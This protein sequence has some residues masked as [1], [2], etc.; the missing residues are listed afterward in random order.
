MNNVK[1]VNKKL[2]PKGTVA[3]VTIYQDS[4]DEK[5]YYKDINGVPVLLNSENNG[6]GGGGTEY[7]PLSGGTMS[8]DIKVENQLSITNEAGT[9]G[10]GIGLNTPISTDKLIGIGDIYDITSP[11]VTG[12]DNLLL[13]G[14]SAL[15]AQDVYFISTDRDNNIEQ[16]F[17]LGTYGPVLRK[18]TSPDNYALM[19][20]DQDEDILLYNRNTEA[21][22]K[23]IIIETQ[24]H[25]TGKV[26]TITVG[27]RSI[28]MSSQ[29]IYIDNLPTHA[30]NIDA[31]AA[32]LIPNAVYKTATGELR[33][34]I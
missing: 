26:S 12:T 4:A 16:S 33:I 13:I 5:L 34:A 11:P 28:R 17:S 32:G 22:E 30:N 9:Y 14:G 24:Y 15:G 19:Q 21:A 3:G 7:L 8:G 6:G 2:V 29:A 10:M 31:R 23:V 25:D 18:D 27:G 20:I 1:R